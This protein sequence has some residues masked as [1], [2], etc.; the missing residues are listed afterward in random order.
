MKLKFLSVTRVGRKN[1][2]RLIN[3][4][5]VGKLGIQ[6]DSM[7]YHPERYMRVHVDDPTATMMDMKEMQLRISFASMGVLE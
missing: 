3:Q 4:S 2:M 7:R 5:C 1:W 6:K